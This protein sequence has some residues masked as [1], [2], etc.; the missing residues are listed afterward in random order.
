MTELCHR[1]YDKKP[2]Y[3]NL[4]VEGFSTFALLHNDWSDP[5]CKP[6]IITVEINRGFNTISNLHSKFSK[7]EATNFTKWFN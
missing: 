6:E 7:S 5:K 3:M 2:N 4:D 1:Y